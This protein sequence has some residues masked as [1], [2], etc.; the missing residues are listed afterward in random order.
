MN[1]FEQTR[2]ELLNRRST[3]L[4]RYTHDR[5][6]HQDAPLADWLDR[7]VHQEFETVDGRLAINE[8]AEI[9]N[10]DRALRRM[11]AGNWGKCM[12]CRRDIDPRRLA[13]MPESSRSE[14]LCT[15]PTGRPARKVSDFA[16]EAQEKFS[17]ASDNSTAATTRGPRV[18]PS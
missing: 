2:K 15:L 8:Q 5:M 9:E 14:S 11:E 12:R 17:D 18:F 10:I 7:A 13:A 6:G 4:D 16:N 3:L 1:D